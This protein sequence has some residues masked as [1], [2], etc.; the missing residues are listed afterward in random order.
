MKFELITSPCMRFAY[1]QYSILMA[2]VTQV[3]TGTDIHKKLILYKN[4]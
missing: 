1:Y 3:S 4:I 2:Q